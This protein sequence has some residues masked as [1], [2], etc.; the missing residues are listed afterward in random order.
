MFRFFTLVLLV[1]VPAFSGGFAHAND[2]VVGGPVAAEVLRVLDGDTFVAEALIWPRQKIT[3]SVRLRGID[4]PEI[5][6]RCLAEKAAGIAAREALATLLGRQG[7]TIS[8]IGGGKYYG[9]VMADAHT[10]DGLDIAET[11]LRQRLVQA[12]DGGRRE[13]NCEALA[14]NEDGR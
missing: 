8:N 5:R 3:V 12:Y 9:R 4:A 14:L 2:A 7:V 1:A 13:R 10:A 11:L 6:S